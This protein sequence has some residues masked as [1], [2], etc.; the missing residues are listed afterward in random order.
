MNAEKLNSLREEHQIQQELLNERLSNELSAVQES[1]QAQLESYRAMNQQKLELAKN[2]PDTA[3][4]KAIEQ[5]LESWGAA[6]AKGGEEGSQAFE[7][8]VKWLNS[9]EDATLQNAIGVELFGTMWED[10]GQ[11]IIDSVLNAD[12]ALKEL[13]KTEQSVSDT[14]N[15]IGETSGLVQLREATENLIVALDPLFTVIANVVGA[16]ANW[17]SNN[18][19]ITAAIVAIG[20]AIGILIGAFA[21][22]GPALL[23]VVSLFGGGTGGTGLLGIL[24]KLGPFLLNCFWT[25]FTTYKCRIPTTTK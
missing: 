1:H 10:Q 25:C 6:I 3:E 4:F 19:K 7:D 17:A 20:S 14:A 11:N 22:I 16:L 2:P 9:I 8:M 24:S 12:D 18:P 5:Q 13:E 23:G 15:Q 21:A